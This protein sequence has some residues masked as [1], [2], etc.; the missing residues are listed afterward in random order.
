MPDDLEMRPV[1]YNDPLLR[2]I[3]R[4]FLEVEVGRLREARELAKWTRARDARRQ[5]HQ[6]TLERARQVLAKSAIREIYEKVR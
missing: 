3:R 4:D 6:Q 2:Q 1:P 5:R